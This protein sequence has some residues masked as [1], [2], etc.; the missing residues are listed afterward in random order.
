MFEGVAW[1]A[2]AG[3]PQ[4]SDVVTDLGGG[5][6]NRFSVS[7]R[8]VRLSEDQAV[9]T[10]TEDPVGVVVHFHRFGGEPPGCA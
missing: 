9:F 6:H 2:D 7:G 5:G 8:M 1:E 3:A 4:I 10:T